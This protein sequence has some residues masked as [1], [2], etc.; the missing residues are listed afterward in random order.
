MDTASP[1]RRA[2]NLWMGGAL[3]APSFAARAQVPRQNIGDMHSHL[4]MYRRGTTGFDLHRKM[5]ESG[6]TLVA[7][8]IVDD[9]SWITLTPQGVKQSRQPGEGALWNYFQMRV[10]GYDSLLRA[11]KLPKALTPADVDAALAGEPHVLMSSESA[12]FLEAKP[13]RVALAHAAGLRH[14]QLVHYIESPLGD[15]QTESPVQNGMAPVTSQVIAECKRLGV[16]VDLAH[17]SPDFIDAA[18]AATD[19]TMIWSHSWISRNGGTWR[20]YAHVARS[21]SPAQAKKIAARGGVV[22][23]WTVRVRGDS[24]YPLYS[25]G[26]YADQIMRMADLLGP[27]HVAFGTDMEGAGPDPIMSEYTELRE[28]V[29]RLAKSGLSEAA[30]NNICIG[31]YARVLKQAMNG[32][33]KV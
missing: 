28:V 18:L 19:A 6:T 21:L 29:E 2:F 22:G 1:S 15:R 9:N 14:L 13:E 5:L 24:K 33:V 27:E 7:W 20:D 17:S 10:K 3:L 26:S 8:A 12:N 25:L 32:A 30:L 23:L 31:N 4:G 11:W 16:L